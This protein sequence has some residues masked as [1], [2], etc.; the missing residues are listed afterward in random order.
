MAV[1]APR[2]ESPYNSFDESLTPRIL[3]KE[4]YKIGLSSKR[5]G[6]SLRFSLSLFM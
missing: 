4:V 6:T 3:E 1:R 5:T 2:A